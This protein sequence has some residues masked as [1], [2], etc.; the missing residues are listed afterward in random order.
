MKVDLVLM[1]INMPIMNGYEATEQIKKISPELPIIAQTAYAMAGD[2]EKIL[3]AG[4]DLYLS[5]PIGKQKL[6]EA[7]N[8][9]LNKSRK[10]TSIQE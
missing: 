3:S 5:K 8:K 4:C 9:C 6:L 7:I 10:L 2:Q 1:D